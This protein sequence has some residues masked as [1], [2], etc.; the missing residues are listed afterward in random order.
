MPCP[1]CGAEALVWDYEHGY[2]VCSN[3][4]V[5]IEQMFEEH[6][7][8]LSQGARIPV[9]MELCSVRKGLEKKRRFAR[10]L[11]LREKVKFLRKYEELRSRARKD[12]I[13]DI[14]AMMNGGRVFVHV[15]ENE[16]RQKVLQDQEV[17]S[18]LENIVNRDPVLS[19]RTF[20]GKVALALIIKNIRNG[21]DPCIEEICKLTGISKT[22][23]RRLL[24]LL[25]KRMGSTLY[26]Y[27]K[28]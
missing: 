5:V 27:A 23:A 9:G 28:V 8:A 7:F 19:S 20:R 17:R 1:N 10:E 24:A 6:Y 16:I 25:R 11:I 14:N 21:G 22:H 15:K 4:G 18:I 13:I 26:Q 12:V 3:C 2:I